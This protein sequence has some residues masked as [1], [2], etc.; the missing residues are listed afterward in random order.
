MKS[1]SAINIPALAILMIAIAFLLFSNS[2]QHS[3]AQIKSGDQTNTPLTYKNT[4]L[5]LTMQYP[6]NW[7]LQKGNLVKNTIA[8]FLLKDNRFH[9]ALDFANITLAEVDLRVYSAPPGVTSSNLN[10]SQL[11]TKG[12]ALITPLKNSSNTLGDLPAIKFGSYVFG[13][14]TQRT[15]QVWTY[16]P[17]KH[18]L[19][20]FVYIAQP[21][22]FPL[23]VS[24]VQQMI[25]SVKIAPTSTSSPP[26]PAPSA[27][28]SAVTQT[29]PSTA[30]G[31]TTTAPSAP[32]SGG[33]IANAQTTPTQNAPAGANTPQVPTNP[34]S[35]APQNPGQNTGS[36]NV[37]PN[38]PS[39]SNGLG[40]K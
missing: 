19:V 8:A 18:V 14:F 29:A 10:L 3:L 32:G 37:G 25:D 34:A 16:I 17:D 6:S 31:S 33:T 24:T 26:G 11:D 9:N 12:Q 5:G 40:G 35:N 39:G 1:T 23:Y 20:A 28:G 15:M 13:G 30:T 38:L 2:Y 4:D 22:T 27:P 7:A 36:P 21:S